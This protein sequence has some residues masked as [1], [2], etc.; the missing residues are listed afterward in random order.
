MLKVYTVKSYVSINGG[1]WQRVGHSGHIMTDNN[2]TE[3]VI[4]NNASM[5]VVNMSASIHWM[6][7]ISVVH[8]LKRSQ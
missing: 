4:L 1:D 3:K 8:C 7:F 5:N 6:V 2:P